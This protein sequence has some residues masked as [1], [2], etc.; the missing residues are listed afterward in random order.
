MRV[1]TNPYCYCLRKTSVLFNNPRVTNGPHAPLAEI[2]LINIRCRNKIEVVG[3]Y[4]KTNLTG[5]CSA[6]DK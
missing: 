2:T 3:N 4:Y 6:D 1:F 5:L